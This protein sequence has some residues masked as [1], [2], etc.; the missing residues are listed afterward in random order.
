M[1]KIKEI[2]EVKGLSQTELAEKLGKSFNMVNLY[3]TN[4]IQP[5]IPVLYQIAE[6]LNIDVRELLVPNQINTKC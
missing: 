6:I 2:L 1:N 3:A 5:P 4:K